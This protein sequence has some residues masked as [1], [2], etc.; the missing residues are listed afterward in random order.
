MIG[1]AQRAMMGCQPG[2]VVVGRVVVKFSGM[3]WRTLSGAAVL[4]TLSPSSS[5]LL[6]VEQIR[7]GV[8][9]A[10]FSTNAAVR[11]S[12]SPRQPAWLGE[13][14]GHGELLRACVNEDS[15]CLR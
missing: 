1:K 6:F 9:G 5:D 4:T 15:K 8:F 2:Q 10:C 14:R 7:A 12:R 11:A 3:N 13:P